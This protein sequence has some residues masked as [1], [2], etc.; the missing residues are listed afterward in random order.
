MIGARLNSNPLCGNHR[1]FIGERRSA[2]LS[3]RWRAAIGVTGLRPP[4]LVTEQFKLPSVGSVCWFRIFA[5]LVVS[6][7]PTISPYPARILPNVLNLRASATLSHG[8]ITSFRIAA[9]LYPRLAPAL[10]TPA[11]RAIA[12]SEKEPMAARLQ[13]QHEIR[14][15][16]N[17]N[18]RWWQRCQR[19]RPLPRALSPRSRWSSTNQF[20]MAQRTGLCLR[21]RLSLR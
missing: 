6:H 15:N 5:A 20:R 13:F 3:S 2:L 1:R 16:L 18:P 11:A 9:G 21:E 4:S 8:I 14:L 17:S 7:M 10:D 12:V 19:I